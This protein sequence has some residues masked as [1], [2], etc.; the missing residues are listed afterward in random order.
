MVKLQCDGSVALVTMNEGE[1]RINQP[2]LDAFE[3]ILL[4]IEETPRIH[5]LVITSAHEKVFSNGLDL[6]WLAPRVERDED[7]AFFTS[8]M[9]F[10]KHL[11]LL[12]VTTIAAISGHAFAGG[13]I[14]SCYCDTRYMRSDRGY[15]CF[16]E[17]AL[18]MSFLP[19]MMAAMKQIIPAPLL[20]DLVCTGR[21]ITAEE[22]IDAG[23]IHK[24]CPREDLLGEAL[25]YARTLDHSREALR[26]I[27]AELRREIVRAIE[28]DDPPF[29][30]ARAYLPAG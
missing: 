20:T 1:N 5:S 21:R 6:D 4:H 15:F 14:L 27:K 11:A 9:D 10:F 19:G 17:V 30:A 12:P 16:P 8:L 24:A 23:F 28:E 18:G 26:G 25:G 29:I 3:E 22:G 2:F 13:A 7:R